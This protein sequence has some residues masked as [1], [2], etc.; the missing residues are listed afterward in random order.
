[1]VKKENGVY[2]RTI[3][4]PRDSLWMVSELITGGSSVLDIGTGV[5]ALGDY[6]TTM[7]KCKVD[8]VEKEQ[9]FA[10][11]ASPFYRMLYSVDI[12]KSKL[13]D[14][15]SD[16][17]YDYIVLADVIEHLRDPGDI[18]KQ[19]PLLMNKGAHLLLSV[20]NVAHAGIIAS[21]LSGDFTYRDDGLLDS[22]HLRFFTR[23]S[24]CELLEL[25]GFR[26]NSVTPLYKDISETEFKEYFIDVYAPAVVR[27]LLAQPDSLTYQFIVDAVYNP[28]ALGVSSFSDNIKIDEINHLS[29]G[30]Q[31]FW[32][33]KNEYYSDRKCVSSSGIIGKDRQCI[34]FCLPHTE[35]TIDKFRLDLSDRPG[36]VNIFSMK[37]L[38]AN[39][40]ELW[41]WQG[42]MA[43]LASLQSAAISFFQATLSIAFC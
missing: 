29:F 16:R 27:A 36:L 24:L 11:K 35:D 41:E 42:D 28:Q 31:L 17:Q 18:L 39:G 5:G 7:K 25:H 26:V 23:T 30:C 33:S 10:N 38:A 13:I 37:L 4:G 32:K 20:P 6:L 3:S 19:I 8:G 22:T 43:Y 9:E 21:L 12:E 34:V 15:I 40:E 14:I 2:D 1:M